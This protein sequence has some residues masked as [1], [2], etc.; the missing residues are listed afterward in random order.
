MI[1][2]LAILGGL[3]E[4]FAFLEQGL[5]QFFCLFH[6]LITQTNMKKGNSASCM[7]RPD[8]AL[9]LVRLAVGLLFLI[10]GIMKFN[11]PEMFQ[12]MLGDMFGLTGGALMLAFWLVVLFEA[13]GGLFVIL[14]KLIPWQLYKVSLFGQLIILLVALFAVHIP[15]EMP[16]REPVILF[17][18]LGVASLVGL[19][20]TPPMCPCGM[21]G[22]TTC[23]TK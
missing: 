8:V 18:I 17:H 16:M 21:T 15:G 14:G 5:V 9:G 6:F 4:K 11:S 3:G 7:S 12:G 23:E 22:C 13:L 19:L 20:V 2:T 1:I 10:P